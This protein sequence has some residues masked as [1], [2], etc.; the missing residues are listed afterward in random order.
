M[1]AAI[2]A[3]STGAFPPAPA[4]A[5][6]AVVCLG[7]GVLS[8]RRAYEAIEWPVIIVLGALIPVAGAME[9]TGLASIVAGWLVDTVVQGRPAVG[10]VTILI[11]TM[12]LSDLINNA[13]T[14]AVMCPI[15]LSAAAR[16]EVSSE[17]FLMA[18]AVGASCAFLTP[19][20]HQNNLLVMGPGGLRFGDYWRLGLPL[21]VLIVSVATPSLLFFWPL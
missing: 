17:P 15:A 3:T 4:F 19:I 16:L 13:A 21:D 14:A 10:V 11:L 2:L 7:F 18:V 12:G 8:Q 9:S 6:A 1:L 20:G 5:V